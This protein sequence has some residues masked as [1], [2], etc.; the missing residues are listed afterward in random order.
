[1]PPRTFS[2]S[3]KA[4][5][6][7]VLFAAKVHLTTGLQLMSKPCVFKRYIKTP[8]TFAQVCEGH[9]GPDCSKRGT[10]RHR[11]QWTVEGPWQR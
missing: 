8:L 9:L 11:A 4:R 6:G 3:S 1:M 5:N 7:C 2:C 10:G